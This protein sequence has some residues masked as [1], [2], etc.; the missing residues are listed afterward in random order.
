M[1]NLCRQIARARKLARAA[2]E[3]QYRRGLRFGV[4][5]ATEHERIPFRR[6]FATVIDVGANRG[7]FALFAVR[8]FPTADLICFEPLPRPRAT[9][10]RAVGPNQHLRVCDFALGATE[11]SADFHV[12][13]AD[14]SSSLLPIGERQQ[15][16]FPGTH[17]R[18]ILVVQVKRLDRSV[19]STGLRR[20]ALLKIDVQGAE[21]EVLSGAANLLPKIDAVL[22]EASF[23]ELYAG[24]ALAD[25]VWER[26]RACGFTCRGAWSVTYNRH[27]ECL[28]ADLLF[29]RAGF[30]PLR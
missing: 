20:P 7:Q 13:A 2:R 11:G 4:A 12:S 10:K 1:T 14:D 19:S 25:E 29:A 9:L 5:A 15:A 17:E 24:Q 16:S 6:D 26:L 23:V 28:Q 3:P 27:G 18:T 30:D 22:V 21:L 8:Q